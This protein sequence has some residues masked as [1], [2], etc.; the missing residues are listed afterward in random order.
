VKRWF[1]LVVGLQILFLLAEAASNE[2]ALRRG[3]VVT[4]KVV[5]VDPR[6]L[7]MGNYM[8]LRY[9]ISTIDLSS[10]RH[11]EPADLFR[12][13]TTVYVG[14]IP[15]KPWARVRSVTIA[16]PSPEETMLYLRGR[17][18]SAYGSKIDI[19]YGLERYFIPE[20]AQERVN[21]LQWRWRGRAPQ[22]TAEVSVARD[23][24]GLIRRVLAD[25]KPWGF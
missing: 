1:Y 13:R 6:S 12:Q 3:Q 21:R 16:L 5:P 22:I 19:A 15:Q 20:T 23:G 25:G 2:I 10:V 7:F 8:D 11:E 24:R 4:L 14:L 18:V 9:D 17:I